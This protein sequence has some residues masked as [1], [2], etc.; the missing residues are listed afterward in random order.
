MTQ[1]STLVNSKRETFNRMQKINKN[2]QEEVTGINNYS[3]N[4]H[5][6]ASL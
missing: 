3:I 5:N 2:F 4:T 6:L 1:I